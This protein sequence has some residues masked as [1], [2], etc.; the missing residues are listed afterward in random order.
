[1]RRLALIGAIL[2][3]AL[4]PGVPAAHAQ[5]SRDD[6]LALARVCV[7]EGGF[8][9]ADRECAA[10]FGVLSRRAARYDMALAAFARVYS[11]LAFDTARTDRRAY[12]AHLRPDG[13]EPA[14]WPSSIAPEGTGPSR[15]QHAPWTAYRRLWLARLESASRILRGEI[16]DPFPTSSHWGGAMDD[17]RAVRAGWIRV[18]DGST[19]NH[20]WRVPERIGGGDRD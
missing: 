5:A 4:V 1:M 19:A 15:A 10:I 2:A 6:V 17:H 16:A 20:F 3:I 9:I 13:H 18:D 7:S 12:V 11:S 14:R 8:R